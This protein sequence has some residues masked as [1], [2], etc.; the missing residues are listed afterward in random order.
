MQATL[1]LLETYISCREYSGPYEPV[2][3]L[4]VANPAASAAYMTTHKS[5]MVPHRVSSKGICVNTDK[6]LAWTVYRT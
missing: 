3:K 6:T 4:T 5:R 1:D 2:S